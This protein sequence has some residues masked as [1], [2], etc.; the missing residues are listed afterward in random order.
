[1]KK[2]GLLLILSV[3]I[4]SCISHQI[5]DRKPASD[6]NIDQSA[7]SINSY[8]LS[9]TRGGK[10]S[11]RVAYNYWSG[12]YPTPIIDVNSGKT[13]TTAVDGYLSLRDMKDI[14][15]CTIKNGV[16]NPW[17]KSD[18]SIENYYT[19]AAVDD[20]LVL[21]DFFMTKTYFGAGV[22]AFEKKIKVPAG[23]KIVNVVYGAENYCT[24]TL[25]IGKNLTPIDE[26]CDFF[27]EN[28]KNL[29]KISKE[30]DQFRE[31][32][33]YLN[34]SEK[35]ESGGTLKVFVNADALMGQKDKGIREGCMGLSY[36]SVTGADSPSCHE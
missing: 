20:F 25:Q 11:T 17:S 1:M 35:S 6:D 36:G 30:N 19:L 13:G 34:C 2:L 3:S 15:T 26:S 21:K 22:K 10:A 5:D 12:E 23:A 29:Q 24:A 9:I 27:Y 16:Y 4:S 28:P 33:L 32:W 31:E 14:R 7:Q 8:K 18:A